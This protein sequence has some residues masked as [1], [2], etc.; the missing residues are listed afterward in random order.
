[1]ADPDSVTKGKRVLLV[2]TNLSHNVSRFRW[3]YRWLDD[4]SIRMARYMAGPYYREVSVLTGS[5]A[6]SSGFLGRINA[7]CDTEL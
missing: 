2:V 4:N 1:M 6:T 7:L 5:R 3:L